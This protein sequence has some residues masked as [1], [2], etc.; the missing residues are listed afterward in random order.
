[1]GTKEQSALGMASVTPVETRQ[2]AHATRTMLV[3][4]AQSP[5]QETRMAPSV[6]AM[7]SVSWRTMRRA[8][9]AN[10][11]AQ[12]RTVV[13]E[14]VVLRMHC[15]MCLLAGACVSLGTPVAVQRS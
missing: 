10:L 3:Q 12:E 13:P 5:A 2:S 9:I 4:H 15:L 8:A 1:M 14:C 11:V 7:A 6:A